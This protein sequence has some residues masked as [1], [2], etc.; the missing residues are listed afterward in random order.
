LHSFVRP[1]VALRIVSALAQ[2]V[3]EGFG[4]RLES[5]EHAERARSWFRVMTGRR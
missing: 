1:P 3:D 4:T 2:P 5:Y